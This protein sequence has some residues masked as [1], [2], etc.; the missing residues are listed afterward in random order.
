VRRT[1][2]ALAALLTAACGGIGTPTADPPPQSSAA[3]VPAVTGI[4]AEAV[5]LRTD[6]AVGGQFQVRV[7]DTGDEP[8]SVTAV[9][10]D[11]PGFAPLPA[12]AVTAD[13]VPGRVIDLPTPY[14]APECGTAPTPALA[15]LTVVRPGGV[16]ESVSV[17]L[18]GDVLER[19]HDEECAVLA[20]RSVVDIGLTGLAADG[21]ALTGTLTLTRRS[22]DER[23]VASRL[24][25]S[26]LVEPTAEE[27]PLV[28]P[29]N[30]RSAS[31]PVSFSPATCDPHVLA[32]TKKPYVFPLAV[33][34]GD[35][36]AVAV[37]LPLDASARDL[38]AAL[39]QRVCAPPA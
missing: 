35:D 18:S 19:I 9:G 13:F 36:E 31:T 3:A 34:V 14:G 11:S 24:S 1:A 27:L 21:D 23:V 15:T 8:F 33:E 10:L 29:R 12:S 30:E 2:L 7:T 16:P 25:R 26:V 28:L 17:P 32:E 20:V 39:V 6:E 38:L 22:G 4:E 5:L 37:D